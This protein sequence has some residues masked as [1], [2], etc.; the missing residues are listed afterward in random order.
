LSTTKTVIGLIPARA[1][2]KRV[3]NKNVRTLAGHPLLAYSICAARES[4]VFSRV[5]VSTDS[6]EIAAIAKNYGAE[7][8]F[9]R[10][11]EFAQDWSPDIEWV[12]HLLLGLDADGGLPDCFSILRPTSPF[13]QPET[14]RRAWARFLDDS[15]AD[16][17]RAVEKCG[18]H[19]AK[20]WLIDGNRMRTV[21]CN[22]DPGAT[23]W[24]SMP[25][26][27]LPEVYVQNASLEIA[28][29]QIPLERGS[30]AGDTIMPF[31]TVN[32]EGL[33]INQPED[34]IIAEYLIEHGR[35]MLPKILLPK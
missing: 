12:R 14:I 29:C 8:P 10:P 4:G 35:A 22:P 30:I 31:V 2:S 17:L 9:L 19:P 1:G 26:Q 6:E 3:A 18:Q 34:W 13:R 33:D 11:V 20:M 16:S 25:Y 7:V 15:Q 5:L 23:P 32:Y 27:V 21:M 28:Y 24:H